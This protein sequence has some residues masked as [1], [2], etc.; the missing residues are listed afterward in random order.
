MQLDR[1]NISKRLVFYCGLVKTHAYM[2]LIN[3]KT[4]NISVLRKEAIL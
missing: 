4:V 1:T 3:K 2:T